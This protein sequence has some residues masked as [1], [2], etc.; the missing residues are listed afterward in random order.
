MPGSSDPAD[1]HNRLHLFH[2]SDTHLG[3]QQYTRT[4]ESG[5]NVREQDIARAF[6]TVIDLAIAER[7]DLV[8]HAG[9]LFDGVRPGNR[10][11]AAAMEGFVRLSQAG[12]PAVVIAGNHEHPKMRETGSPFRLFAHLPGIHVV[13]QGHRQSLDIPTQKGLVRVHAVPQCADS[14]CLAREI[15][16]A[17]MGGPGIDVLVVHG[18]VPSLKAF[19]H[20]EFNELTLDPY[21]FRPFHYVALGHYHGVQQVAPNAWYCGAPERVSIAEAGQEKGFLDVRLSRSPEHASVTFRPLPGRLYLDLPPIDASG[22]DAAQTRAAALDAI[23]RIPPGAVARLRLRGLDPALRGTLDLRAL[24]QAAA[25]CIHFDL[26]LEWADAGLDV[27]A[28]TDLRGVAQEFDAFAAQQ[29]MEGI[30]RAAV[31]AK[32]RIALEAP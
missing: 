27:R 21:Q 3:H 10:A 30:P 17:P 24:R 16:A 13:F 28:A 14:E 2:F 6:R 8:L 1:G 4:D 29:P 15:G 19:S 26:L 22:L 11:L 32:A 31:L 5:L 23:A 9:D 20:A 7:P 18:A 12:I 25:A